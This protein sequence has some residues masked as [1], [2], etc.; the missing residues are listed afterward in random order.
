MRRYLTT[1]TRSLN[2][3]E[4]ISE[5]TSTRYDQVGQTGTSRPNVNKIDGRLKHFIQ[6]LEKLTS[7]KFILDTVAGYKIE[8]KP[9]AL[10]DH[11]WSCNPEEKFN[12]AEQCIIDN[13][14]DK[15]LIFANE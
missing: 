12:G 7:D 11:D 9:E 10:C 2:G 13:E 8:F 14:I 6:F 3:Q 1:T 4:K 15:L 5:L